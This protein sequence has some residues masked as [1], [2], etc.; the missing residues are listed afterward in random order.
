M[1]YVIYLMIVILSA[2]KIKLKNIIYST[3]N[4]HL[5]RKKII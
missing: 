2:R 3:Y 5:V 4:N 1:T